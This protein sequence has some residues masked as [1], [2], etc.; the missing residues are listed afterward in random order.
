MSRLGNRVA[1]CLAAVGLSALGVSSGT[2]VAATPHVLLVGSYNGVTGPY[3][4]IQAAVNAAQAGDW[5]LVGPGDYHERADYIDPNPTRHA[6]VAIDVSNLHLRGMNRN[7]V[8]V[9]GT[10]PGA[11]QCSA[12]LANQDPGKASAGRN[13]IEVFGQLGTANNVTI[14]NLTACNFLT[15]PSGGNGNQ[16]WWNGGDGGGQ[17]HMNGFTGNYLTATS[18]YSNYVD[19]PAGSYGIFVSNATNGSWSYD[20]ASNMADSS[21]YIGACQQVC[22]THMNYDRGQNS[23]L[24][25]SSTNA[26]GY[27]LVE[28]TEC[29]HNKTGLVSN[30]QN[31][32][33]W[34]SPQKGACPTGVVGPL[35]AITASCTVW[36]NNYLHDN[37]NPN[38]PGNGTSGLSGA[39]PVGT[40]A[41]LAGTQ[42]V[43][44]YHNRISNNGSWGEL[45]VDLPDQEQAPSEAPDCN[46]GT[47]VGP[48]G[49]S[50]VCY[51][52]ATGN[53]SLDN[54][55][56]NNGGN[57]NP[58]NGDIGLATLPNNP[59]N[60]FSG[61]TD[62]AALGGIATTDPIGMEINPAFQPSAAPA[63]CAKQ[64]A[65][66]WAATGSQALCASQ[67][68]APCPSIQNF[69]CTAL[70]Q[71]P[72]PFPGVPGN[73][74]P[75]PD[76]AVFKLSMPPAQTT[77]ADPCAGVPANPFC[78][79]PGPAVAE[80]P[81]LAAP[82]G[83]AVVVLAA[84]SLFWRR[85]RGGPTALAPGV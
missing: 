36:A 63:T 32:D 19:Y 65:G 39:G 84:A 8:V 11:P 51:F 6:G 17:V 79:T 43:T 40:G 41:I 33:D 24:C 34:P 37:N 23:A 29:D 81:L 13:G 35:P 1:A 55:F 9:D 66:D 50:E 42:N 31:N 5:V 18:T 72:C 25:L 28:N 74:F 15:G 58:G 45:V 77:M 20:Y 46:G 27:I 76:P 3:T 26:G 30:A 60:C 80:F 53:I 44:L 48:S 85:R 54:I 21:Y 2:V 56:S 64:N 83:G 69:V 38:V 67:L 68:A 78:P 52:R 82:V 59:G 70:A 71:N 61:D 47:L 57:G 73:N 62:A 14:E 75:R 12:T 4:T 10:K 49:S 16:I 7:T 22:N